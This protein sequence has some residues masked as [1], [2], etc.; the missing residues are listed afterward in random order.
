MLGIISSDGHNEEFNSVDIFQKDGTYLNELKALL[1]HEGTLYKNGDGYTLRITSKKLSDILNKYNICG[2]KRYSVP[3]MK[4]P[5]LELESCYIRGLFDGD[6]CIYFNYVSG[7]LKDKRMEITTGSKLMVEGIE[8]LYKR[9]NLVYE[10]S[11]RTSGAGNTYYV[12]YV[13]RP[14][15]IIKLGKWIYSNKS[16]KFKLIQKYIKFLKFIGILSLNKKVEDIV[17]AD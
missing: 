11:E 6:G 15:E 16:L 5:T 7:T 4:A 13:R 9:L 10:I 14:E 17:D 8:D 3:Y 1:E 2:D 12:I